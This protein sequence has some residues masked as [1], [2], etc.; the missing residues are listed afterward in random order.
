MVVRSCLVTSQFVLTINICSFC[1]FLVIFFF[2]FFFIFLSGLFLFQERL[3]L[4]GKQFEADKA[5]LEKIRLLLVCLKN[6]L[7]SFDSL[8]FNNF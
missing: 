5:K 8:Y 7:F 3:E 4:I 6:P 2:I 1:F